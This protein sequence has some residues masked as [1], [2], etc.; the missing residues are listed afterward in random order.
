MKRFI[1]FIFMLLSISEA[2][3]QVRIVSPLPDLNIRITQ[4]K[5]N[6]TS[7]ILDFVVVNQEKD[8]SFAMVSYWNGTYA[9]DDEGNK[10]F[11]HNREEEIIT[12]GLPNDPETD[13]NCNYPTDVPI[14]IRMIV[15]NV[16]PMAASLAIVSISTNLGSNKNIVFKNVPINKD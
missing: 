1:L 13:F 15:N 4:C 12:I 5:L 8:R 14:K 7:L 16:D 11:S 6:N 10:Y 2:T 3:A 9:I